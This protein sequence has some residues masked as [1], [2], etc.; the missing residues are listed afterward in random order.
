MLAARQ[1]E[2]VCVF[3]SHHDRC[4]A[5]VETVKSEFPG[6]KVVIRCAGSADECVKDADLIVTVTTSAVPGFDG[7]AVKPGATISCVGTYE[8]D[9]HEIDPA[10]IV[11]ADKIFCDNK[12]AVLSESGDILIPLHQGLIPESAVCGGLG[13]VI[14][15]MIPGRESDDEIVVFE[16]VGIAGQDLMTSALIYERIQSSK[17]SV[18]NRI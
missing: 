3:S 8:P 16:T 2:E 5:F 6:N 4:A 7:S 10:L 15:G 13:E 17:D 18:R 12:D 1:L 14:N 9:K 11:R